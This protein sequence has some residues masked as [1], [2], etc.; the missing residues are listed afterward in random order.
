MPRNSIANTNQ[1]INRMTTEAINQRY[2]QLSE[3]TCCLSCG[4]AINYAKPLLGEVCVDLGSGRGNDVIRMA[5]QV[6]E[7]GHILY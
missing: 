5:E 2:I 4:G 6:G 7:T 3:S 1:P